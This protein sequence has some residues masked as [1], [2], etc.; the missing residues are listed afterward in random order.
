MNSIEI[1]HSGFFTSVQDLGRYG[2]Q[3]YGVVVSGAMDTFALRIANLLVGNEETAAAL[4]MTLI[5]SS[6]RFHQDTLIA[7]CGGNLSPTIDEQPVP[8]WRPVYIKKGAILRFSQHSE[9]CRSYLALGGA[10]RVPKILNSSS[11]Y[12][13]AKLGG[14]QGRVLK[15]NDILQLGSLSPLG[16][17]LTNSLALTIG[18]DSFKGV[19]W[20]V[21]PN[22][23]PKY[24]LNP[25]IRVLSGPQLN[26]FST[27]SKA[28]FFNDFFLVT[29]QS[30]RMGYRLEGPILKMSRTLEMISEAVSGGTIQ[31]PPDGNPIILLA[32]RQTTGGYP[33]IAQ[34]AT[35]DLPVIAQVK[36]GEKIRFQ[37][38]SLQE[39]QKLLMV[40]ERDIQLLKQ[41]LAIR[42]EV[43]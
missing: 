25:T 35:I 1:V 33:K 10:L 32:D 20:A 19:S 18:N 43:Y 3:K 28:R 7:I 16:R 21:S 42:E 23:F 17:K 8:E 4:E 2:F 26:H 31:V 15:K 13:R 38:I 40:K 11:T 22:I 6:L 34:I 24:K 9:G 39:A 14:F 5:G 12:L 30:D 29:T 27:E 41:A 37:E 36:P